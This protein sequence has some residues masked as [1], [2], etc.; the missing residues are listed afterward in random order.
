VRIYVRDIDGGKPRALTPEK[1]G[2]LSGVSPD[3]RR[4]IARRADSGF[5]VYSLEGGEPTPI[6]GL[7]PDDGVAGWT[8]QERFIYVRRG[9]QGFP[10]R[11]ERLDLAT[12]HSEKWKDVVPAD[13]TGLMS[14]RMPHIAPDGLSYTYSAGRVLS[15]LFL[16]DG[17]K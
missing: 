9:G 13:Q 2:L 16:V 17:V 10:A 12:G 5:A 15:A 11:I 8:A 6:P 3:G 14:V 4:F 1:C 7:A